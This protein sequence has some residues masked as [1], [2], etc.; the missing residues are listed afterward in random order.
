[1]PRLSP[2]ALLARLAGIGLVITAGLHASG[3]SQ[4]AALAEPSQS[5]RALVPVLWLAISA[6]LLGLGLIVLAI[7]WRPGPGARLLLAIAALPPLGQALLLI[8]YLGWLPQVALYLV[9]AGLCLGAA[10]AP[11]RSPARANL[12]GS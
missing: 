12:P 11:D 1:M 6:D 4:V 7:G 10:V 2:H 9:L 5:L 3:L 8:R